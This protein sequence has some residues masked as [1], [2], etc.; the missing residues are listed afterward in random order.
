MRVPSV[1]VLP[2]FLVVLTV[3]AAACADSEPAPVDSPAANES[4]VSSDGATP[5]ADPPGDSVSPIDEP[6]ASEASPTAAPPSCDITPAQTEGP[7]YF[8]TGEFRRDITEGLPGTPVLVSLRIVEA[9]SCEPVAGAIVD[10]WHT[11][12]A[13]VYSGYPDQGDDTTGETFLRGKQVTDSNGI[14]EFETIYPGWYPTRAVH[15]HFM[16]QTDEGHLVTSQLYFPDAV[17][18][19]VYQ[20]EPYAARGAHPVTNDDNGIFPGDTVDSLL[21]G[22]VTESAEGYMISLTVGVTPGSATASSERSS[23]G[24]RTS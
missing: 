12:I 5:E 7:Y 19:A 2:L 20:T 1:L 13:G 15:I 17:S 24:R 6:P 10:I 23:V 18:E 16:A 11:D 21:I 8:D 22:H 4:P 3:A 9:G 14:A